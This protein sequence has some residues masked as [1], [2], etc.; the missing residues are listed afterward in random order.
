MEKQL[1][2]LHC[3]EF[4][5]EVSKGLKSYISIHLFA[6]KANVDSHKSLGFGSIGKTGSVQCPEVL[7]DQKARHPKGSLMPKL[8]ELTATS[9]G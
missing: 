3:L 6:E 4:S 1:I 2:F 5:L 7:T 9:G 8:G